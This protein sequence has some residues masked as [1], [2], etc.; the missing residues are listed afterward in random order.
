[1][2]QLLIDASSIERFVEL[3][4]HSKAVWI[5]PELRN[6]VAKVS[7][8]SA[9]HKLILK[10]TGSRKK[11]K[12]AHK[13]AQALRDYEPMLVHSSIR[14]L[15]SSGELR[16]EKLKEF[17]S[18]TLLSGA[19]LGKQ[20]KVLK[21]KQASSDHEGLMKGC[22]FR[23]NPDRPT[24]LIGCA[25]HMIPEE[26]KEFLVYFQEPSENMG[27]RHDR[28]NWDHYNG[29][30]ILVRIDEGKEV[31]VD[32]GYASSSHIHTGINTRTFYGKGIKLFSGTWSFHCEI[33]AP[34]DD[35]GS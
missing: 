12:A 33:P 26:G 4:A 6:M 3:I 32:T 24:T 7:S 18:T 25:S 35:S 8:P 27:F 1:M 21:V 17:I 14:Y 15:E 2:K 30:F 29:F 20:M 16:P 11:A 13:L 31:V 10:K 22:G 28:K 5:N 23:H 9:A 19:L 34:E